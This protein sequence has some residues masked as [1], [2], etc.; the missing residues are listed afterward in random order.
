M[1]LVKSPLLLVTFFTCV[2]CYQII[3]Q[4]LICA[5]YILYFSQHTVLL[6]KLKL[7]Y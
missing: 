4:T 3:I 2:N 5:G 7:S 6:R 1:L